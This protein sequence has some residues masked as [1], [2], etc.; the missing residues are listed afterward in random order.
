MNILLARDIDITK[1]IDMHC[2]VY[3][4]PLPELHWYNW[5]SSR[6]RLVSNACHWI[7]YF[8]FLNSYADIKEKYIWNPRG[9]DLSIQIKLINEAYLSFSLTDVGSIRLGVRDY[10]ELRQKEITVRMLD[11]SL[12]IAED[13]NKIIRRKKINPLQSYSKM[14]REISNK[15]SRR[16]NGDNLNSLL[17]SRLTLELE[18]YNNKKS[19]N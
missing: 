8:L 6:S 15:I 3:E 11:S 4:I 12:Y 5:P 14:Y 10:I 18:T 16:E 7:D 19:I 1:P 13:N 17:S 9:N 2:I